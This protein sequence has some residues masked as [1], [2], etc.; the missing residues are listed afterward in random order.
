MG[1]KHIKIYVINLEKRKDRLKDVSKMLKGY[2]WER[3]EAIETKNG[4]YGCVLSHIKCLKKAIKEG[5][6]EVIIMEDDHEIKFPRNF[7]Y[8]DGRWDVCLLTG[9]SVM[10]ENL[11]DKFMKISSARH[12]DCYMVKGT[13]FLTMLECFNN[14]LLELLNEYNHPN[15][16]DVY[17]EKYMEKDNF[18][19]LRNLIGGQRNG[20]SDILNQ[21]R[22]RGNE[23]KMN[24]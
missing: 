19:C 20:L 6:P 13:Y 21:T 14:S 12:T 17:W 15:F 11:N 5:L 23:I 16:L 3:V 1:M 2:N 22:N 24:F 4:Y 9:K 8:P 7:T 10:G 18:L